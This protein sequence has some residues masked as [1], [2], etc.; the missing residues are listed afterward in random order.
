MDKIKELLGQIGASK[1]L[2]DQ[3]CEHLERYSNALKEKYE[4]ELQEKIAKAKQICIEEVQKEKVNLAR[5]VG[6]FLESKAAS[7]EQAM[8]RQRVAE[9]SEA[10][11]LL[12]KTKA[13]LE[14]IELEGEVSSRELLALQKKAGRLEKAIGTLKE[15]RNRAIGKAN[16]ANEVAV[17]MLKR[18]QLFEAKLK[19]AGLLVEEK[20]GASTCECGSPMGEGMSKCKKC[21]KTTVTGKEKKAAEKVAKESRKAKSA[22]TEGRKRL[23]KSR[24]APGKPK[25]TRRTLVESETPGTY[26]SSGSPDISKIASEMPE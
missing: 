4:G 14:G 19:E 25:S 23:D 8:T 2:A 11:S 6:T 21:N 7:I 13:L 18:N 20:G 3:L 10:S 1:E 17:K 24:K 15:E 12:K 26:T 5:K 16:K 9:E 22:I